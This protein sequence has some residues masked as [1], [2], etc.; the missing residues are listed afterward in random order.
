MPKVQTCI[1]TGRGTVGLAELA[2]RDPGPGEALIRTTLT[3]ICGSDLHLVD[4]IDRIPT[5]WPQGHE[6]VGVVEAVGAGVTQLR[7]GDRVVA[8]CVTCCGSCAL[9]KL[10]DLQLC[11]TYGS[12]LNVMFG[13]QAEA[14]VVRSAERNLAKIPDA[15]QDRQ[16]IFAADIMSTGFGAIERGRL[17]PG[18]TVAVYAQ[19]PVGLCA[20][21]AAKHYGAGRIIAVEA[22]PERAAMA[23]RLGADDVLPPE[24]APERI[25]ELTGGLGVDLAVEA[26][27][28]PATFDACLRSIR[29]GGTVS[30]VGVFAGIEALSLPVSAGFY[31]ET[32]VTTLCPGGTA[33]LQYL[34]GLM[35]RGQVDLTP[36]FT[37]TMPLA[38]IAAAYDLFRERK[39]GVLK[40]A[41]R[42]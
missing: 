4:L 6:A 25:R 41:L 9:C 17:T 1:K 2:L 27:G 22:L 34:M 26:L 16:A 19:G 29:L 42:V 38:D 35:E 30:V 10:G 14:F 40:I 12:P 5:G 8:S 18:Q 32:I 33:R 20:T 13:C 24:G 3:T 23:K 11:S 39:D 36:M 31:Q 28:K 15:M 37:H 21:A 7:P